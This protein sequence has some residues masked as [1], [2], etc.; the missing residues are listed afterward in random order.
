MHSTENGEGVTLNEMDFHMKLL[1]S[2]SLYVSIQNPFNIQK[3]NL[4]KKG[5]LGHGI[6]GK[7]DKVIF[8]LS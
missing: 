1:R 6:E 3:G 7:K 5:N 4:T 8:M 2:L